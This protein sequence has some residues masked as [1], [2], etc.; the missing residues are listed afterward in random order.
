MA[1][2]TAQ[3]LLHK[4]AAREERTREPCT[5]LG[6]WH[7]Q[8]SMQLLG[9]HSGQ[10]LAQN[11][12]SLLGSGPRAKEVSPLKTALVSFLGV[13]IHCRGQAGHLWLV[14]PVPMSSMASALYQEDWNGWVMKTRLVCLPHHHMLYRTHDGWGVALRVLHVDLEKQA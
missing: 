13:S 8:H 12:P 4:D 6:W 1:P 14:S 2:Q 7:A 11:Q 9:D 3:H 5:W 10:L